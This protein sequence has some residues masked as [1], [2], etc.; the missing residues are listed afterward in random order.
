MTCGQEAQVLTWSLHVT[1]GKLFRLPE[2][3]FPFCI[4]AKTLLLLD[5]PIAKQLQEPQS[6]IKT[7]V[8][9]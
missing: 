5:D 2:S 8:A 9:I 6:T 1:L 3:C 7:L 4:M